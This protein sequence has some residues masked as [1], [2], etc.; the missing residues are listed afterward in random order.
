MEFEQER[1]TIGES[2]ALAGLIAMQPQTSGVKRNNSAMRAQAIIEPSE[3]LGL[4]T[5]E[6]A[7]VMRMDQKL[8]SKPWIEDGRKT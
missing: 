1:R 3:M 4:E 7:E 2:V 5:G 6:L 8:V